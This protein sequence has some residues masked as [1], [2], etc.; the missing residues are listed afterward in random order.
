MSLAASGKLS[1]HKVEAKGNGPI[2]LAQSGGAD[3]S[4]PPHKA[5]FVY[6]ADLIQ[7]DYRINLQL[8]FSGSDKNF[9]RVEMRTKL[10]SDRCHNGRGGFSITDVVLDNQSR[11]SFLDLRS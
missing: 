9:Y 4:E 6:R 3:P 5:P 2:N 8:T 10:R 1:T 11:A 7:A